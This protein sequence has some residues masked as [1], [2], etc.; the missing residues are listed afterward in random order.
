MLSKY[1]VDI[2]LSTYNGEK[3]LGELLDS[4]FC[5]TCQNWRL[6]VRDDGSKDNT[7][8]IIKDYIKKYGQD[9]IVLVPDGLGNRGPKESFGQLMEYSQAPYV[10]FCDQDDVWLQDKIELSF[11]EILAQENRSGK[12]KPM[13][14][15]TNCS[16]VDQD[17]NLI[18]VDAWKHLG[19]DPE[20]AGRFHNLALRNFIVGHTIMMNRALLTLVNPLPQQAVMHD[21]W[22]GL[23]AAAFGEIGY[24]MKPT[25]LYRQH[26]QNFFGLKR[27]PAWKAIFH[28]PLHYKNYVQH[29]MEALLQINAF[30]ERF[31]ILLQ[32][33]VGNPVALKDLKD[34]SLLVSLD[35]M[36]L[37]ERI[38]FLWQFYKT[39]PYRE[40]AYVDFFWYLIH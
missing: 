18:A 3:F 22:V 7:I 34:V 14:V 32:K 39:F 13:L 29:Q 33:E 11:Q 28:L 37:G 40:K 2:L 1:E 24:V 21:W 9:K 31:D 20:I 19:F 16:L 15:S 30:Y 36:R 10:M 17:L 23:A 27:I 25:V 5:Q 38:C 12:N 6:V 8:S 4:L 35:Q 26:S